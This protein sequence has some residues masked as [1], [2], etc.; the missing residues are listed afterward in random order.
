MEAARKE[1]GSGIVIMNVKTVKNKGLAA[2]FRPR[3]MEVTV[4]LEEES[5][6]VQVG[7]RKS[8]QVG[9]GRGF[10]GR[11][12]HIRRR[13]GQA[14]GKGQE[15]AAEDRESIERKLDNLQNLLVSRFQ[16]SEA[17]RRELQE[18]DGEG[19]SEEEPQEETP[20]EREEVNEQ[21]RFLKL[22]Y[23]TMLD[24]E[25]DEKYA[26]QIVDEIDVGDSPICPLIISWPT[27][28]RR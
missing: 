16:Q 17:E 8:A 20:E 25:I 27:S 21:Q 9:A 28:I 26:N 7:Q 2:L 12:A 22:L 5:D 1:L 15:A 3:Q 18:E 4:A 6:T 13:R 23:N 24:S 19:Y 10:G 11:T 14:F